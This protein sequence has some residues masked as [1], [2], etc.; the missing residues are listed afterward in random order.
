MSEAIQ[1]LKS[2]SNAVDAMK[3]VIESMR[4]V[5]SA[6]RS[7]DGGATAS[8]V[9]QL[10]ELKSQLDA[11]VD[12]A[13]YK[14]VNFLNGDDLDV[15]FNEDGSSKLSVTGV[16]SKATDLSI[17][18]LAAT[19]TG[20]TLDTLEGTL[21]TALDTLRDTASELTANLSVISTRV[22]FTDN[23]VNTLRE[24]AE[25]LTAAD[26]NAESANLL[27]LQTRQQL[28]MTALAMSA[29]AAQSVLR[30]F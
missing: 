26:M 19:N 7:T 27:A 14:G 15:L 11:I 24:G 16:A 20:S 6:A 13:G 17:G 10:T 4:G 21:N 30:L 22:T 29:Q 1:T 8:Q 25:K 5:I 2:S 12:D 23:M 3:G 18:T 9:A 28:G